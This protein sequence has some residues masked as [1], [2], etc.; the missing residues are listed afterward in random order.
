MEDNVSGRVGAVILAA[1]MS[2][3]MGQAKLVLPYKGSTVIGTVL[4]ALN[5]AGVSPLIAVTGGAN[6]EV[7][8]E[9]KRLPFDVLVTRNPEPDQTEM[10]DSLRLGMKHLP[11][12]LDAFLIV[13]GDQPQIQPEIVTRMVQEFQDSHQPLI[14]PSYKMRRGH[15]W[16]IGRDLWAALQ[17]MQPQ[18]TMRDFLNQNSDRI[19]YL[20]VDTNSI[21]EDIDTPEDYR[22]ASGSNAAS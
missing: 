10:M 18:Q 14:I 16:L 11:E 8:A 13:L 19:N 22:R 9:I 5:A 6:E 1:G 15:P 2:R 4:A 7:E 17:G 21:L 20:D 12:F 3:R